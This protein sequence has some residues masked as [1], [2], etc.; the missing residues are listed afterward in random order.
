MI[1]TKY[2]LYHRYLQ[3]S[4]NI[5]FAYQPILE[6]NIYCSLLNKFYDNFKCIDSLIMNKFY[7]QA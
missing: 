3:K 6:D 1:K 5:L 2:H 7:V 4:K